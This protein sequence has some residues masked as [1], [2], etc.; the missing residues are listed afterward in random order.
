MYGVFEGLMH[1]AY[2]VYDVYDMN[3]VYGVK[4]D[5]VTGV[6]SLVHPPPASVAHPI[7]TRLFLYS[8]TSITDQIQRRNA[9]IT[10]FDDRLRGIA[11]G[12]TLV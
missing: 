11:T 3:S 12:P 5:Y 4:V 1:D 6:R 9:D 10:S 7:G 2:G 8:F